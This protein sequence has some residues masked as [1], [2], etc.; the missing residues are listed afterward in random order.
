MIS[1]LN[2]H[3]SAVSVDSKFPWVFL[4]GSFS[5]VISP[6]LLSFLHR[7]AVLQVNTS[8]HHLLMSVLWNIIACELWH[9][10]S[11]TETEAKRCRRH[12]ILFNCCL[13]SRKQLKF[14]SPTQR[15]F[16]HYCVLFYFQGLKFISHSRKHLFLHSYIFSAG[17]KKSFLTK[18]FQENKCFPN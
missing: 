16:T 12:T 10:L 4:N 17:N 7:T 2:V 9:V 6:F 8:F 11:I 1:S 14:T 18:L 3:M 15:P 13:K 5:S